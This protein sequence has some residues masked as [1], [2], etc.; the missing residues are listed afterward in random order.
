MNMFR[1]GS[2]A[3]C[4]GLLALAARPVAAASITYDATLAS[5][6]GVVGTP[7]AGGNFYNGSGD[8]DTNFTIDTENGI[9][10]AL[11]AKQRGNATP[12]PNV[13]NVYSVPIGADVNNA[14]RAWWNYD[15]SIDLRPNGIGTLLLTDIT[16]TLFIEDLVHG[17][18]GTINPLG[19]GDNATWGPGGEGNGPGSYA[20]NWGAQNSENPTFFAEFGAAILPYAFNMNDPNYFRLT[21]SVFQTV[22]GGPSTLLGASSIDV[23]VGDAIPAPEPASMILLGTGLLGA[24]RLRHR[25]RQK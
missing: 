20:T 24:A 6:S 3:L 22:I 8:Y 4:L 19:I 12:V 14:A 21:L 16:A 9:E 23:Q 2:M 1:H 5:P 18:S 15:F 13:L 11:R 7:P 17:G 25:R 10:V